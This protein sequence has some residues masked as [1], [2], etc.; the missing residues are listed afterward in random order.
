MTAQMNR[1]DNEIQARRVVGEARKLLSN[2]TLSCCNHRNFQHADVYSENRFWLRHLESMLQV[3]ASTRIL[4][5]QTEQ[6]LLKKINLFLYKNNVF[7]VRWLFFVVVVVFLLLFFFVF[8][9]LLVFF[10]VF[11]FFFFFFFFF[12]LLLLIIILYVSWKYV[13]S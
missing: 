12:V 5:D 10:C 2:I 11:F 13:P 3:I 7:S 9:F 6:S 1:E 4:P 8:V